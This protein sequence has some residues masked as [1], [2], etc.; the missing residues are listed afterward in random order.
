MARAHATAVTMLI[1]LLLT[2]CSASDPGDSESASGGS[3]TEASS[4]DA[5]PSS[6]DSVMVDGEPLDLV[7]DVCAIG[8]PY[9]T[10]DDR[11]FSA[12]GAGGFPT[13]AIELFM[14]DMYSATFSNADGTSNYRANDP[15]DFDVTITAAGATGS[16]ALMDTSGATD[17]VTITFDFTCAEA[18]ASADDGSASDDASG[19]DASD[20]SSG[21]KTGY[22]DWAGARSDLEDSDF[23]PTAGTGLCETEDV[24]GL[25]EGDYYRISTTLDD[26]TDFF[27]TSRDGLQLGETLSPIEV[28]ALS[29]T[30]DGRTV[31]GSAQTAEGPLEFSF[32]C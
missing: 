32:T 4:T 25:E 30:Q 11:Q 31:S 24:T 19:D 17:N 16:V 22:V 18:D 12:M 28:S 29:V 10:E 3:M 6:G 14:P 13:F 26:G 9:G 7:T 1:A 27:L 20:D 8:G 21:T 2:A 5:G 23:D 15:A